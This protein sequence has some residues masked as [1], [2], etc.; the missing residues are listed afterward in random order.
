[1]EA[2][3]LLFSGFDTLFT[4]AR[5]SFMMLGV[6]LGLLVGVLP[7]VGGTTG[8][9]ILLP[10]TVFF[11]PVSALVMLAGIYWGAMYGGLITSILFGVPGNPWSVA[12][13]FDGR[14]LAKQGKAGLALAA[15]FWVS[16]FGAV[17]ASVLFTFFAVPF[18]QMALRFGPPEMFAVLMIAFGTFIGLGGSPHKAL[19]MIA[20]GFLLSTVGL[21][22]VTGQPRLTFGS[23]EMMR[24]FHFVPVTIGLFGIGEVLANAAERY[25]VQIED[26]TRAAKLGLHDITA[27]GMAVL[28]NFGTA[29]FAALLGFCTGILPG[30]GATPA[31]FMAYG[32][33][34]KM[35]RHPEK[36][37]KGAIEGVI[38]PEAAN[39]AAGTGAILPM[40]VL[41]IPGSPTAAILMAG[42]FMWGFIPGPRLFTDQ[43]EFVWSF[44][45][46]LYAANVAAVVICLTATP[47][48]A[49]MLRTPYAILAPLI[50]VMSL[51]G[52][53]AIQNA[54]LDVW[55][56]VIFGVIGFVLR[57]MDYPLAPL[58][59]ALVLGFST[60]EALRQS[61]IMS[62]GSMLIFFQRPISTP[63]MIV[64]LL[65]FMLPV[66]KI[67][68]TRMRARKASAA[69]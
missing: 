3:D 46:S 16:F 4:P 30:A 33:A 32:V 20:A 53:Y 56:A 63:I 27:G 8:V 13:M 67:V 7:G 64:A 11:E 17:V 19:I 40:L 22:V 43:P 42:V 31:S 23:I 26:V 12:V 55:L 52:A 34:Q 49:M 37:G 6:I 5:I 29:T 47:L 38:A 2:L 44:I 9:A 54:F 69:E 39:N 50:V 48:L 60:E 1:M 24:G 59:V 21:D 18:A 65:L 25:K 35:S 57:R 15:G 58:V 41:G 62:D 28:R 66:F 61:L 14:P 51:I 10:V 68:I 36:F 45:A